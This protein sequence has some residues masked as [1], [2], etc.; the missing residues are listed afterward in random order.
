MPS[1]GQLKYYFDPTNVILAPPKSASCFIERGCRCRVDKS[2]GKMA[3]TSL[4]L[5]I[6]G[7]ALSPGQAFLVE[8]EGKRSM[9]FGA[10]IIF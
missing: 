5:T 1:K 8:A 2:V 10:N 4:Q 7:V 3:A 9:R 6:T